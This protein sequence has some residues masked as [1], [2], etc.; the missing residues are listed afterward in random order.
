MK[1]IYPKYQQLAQALRQEILTGKLPAGIQ[2]PT[3]E[4]L[5]KQFG[6]SRETVRKAIGQLE[7][8]GFIRRE[9]GSG[10]YVNGPRPDAVAFHFNEPVIRVELGPL[11]IAYRVLRQEVLPATLEDAETLKVTPG[12]AVIHIAQVKLENGAPVSYSERHL[13]LSLCPDL[14]SADLTRS[15]VHDLLLT[16]VELPP[17]RAVIEIEARELTAIEAQWL[18]MNPGMH[19]ITVNR[20]SYTAPNQPAVWYRGIFKERYTMGVELE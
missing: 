11:N 19:A 3:E 13:P 20:L 9:Q 12:T 4:M 16:S 17:M 15:S 1:S 2:I 10:S 6:F 18:A 8:E 7:T 14:A 5:V